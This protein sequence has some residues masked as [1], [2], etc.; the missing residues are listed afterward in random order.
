MHEMSLCEGVLQLIENN[1][2]AQG[3]SRVHGVKLEIGELAGVDA[4]ALRFS[5][6]VVTRGTLADA[7]SL[8][9]LP[10]PGQAWC[11]ACSRTVRISRRID[12]CPE[13]GSHQLQVT[14]GDDMML[15]SLEVE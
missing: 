1:A 3:F 7:A 15:K 12:P 10:V 14:G 5:F 8:D 2:A 11:M 13:C 4:E 6:D 9:I